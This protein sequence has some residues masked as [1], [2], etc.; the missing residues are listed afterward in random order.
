MRIQNL[1]TNVFECPVV[2]WDGTTG[3]VAIVSGGSV[4]V[5]GVPGYVDRI[6]RAREGIVVPTVGLVVTER[7]A[8]TGM[9]LYGLACGA[10]IAGVI[11]ATVWARRAVR[12]SGVD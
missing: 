10:P 5:A 3:Q 1:T 4:E 12:V 9:M 6:D 11:L 7:P 8:P 2:L